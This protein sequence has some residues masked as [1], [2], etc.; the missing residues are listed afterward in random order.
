[1]TVMEVPVTIPPKTSQLVI[2]TITST[3]PNGQ[4]VVVTETSYVPPDPAMTGEGY[5]SNEPSLHNGASGKGV[6]GVAVAVVMG[7]MVGVVMV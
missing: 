5:T 1:M 4:L 7:V 6:G 2:A 3:R